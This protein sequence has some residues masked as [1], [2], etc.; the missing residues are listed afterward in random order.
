MSEIMIDLETLSTANNASILTI[1]AIRFDRNSFKI[2]K[3]FYKRITQESNEYYNRDFNQDTIDWWTTQSDQAK[4]EIF[5][6]KNRINLN[7]GL[8]ELS[9]FCRGAKKIW[10]NGAAFDIPILES[11]YEACGLEVPWK[12][13]NVRDVRTIYDLGDLNLNNFKRQN[14]LLGQHH[15][16]LADCETQLAAMEQAMENIYD[17]CFVV[18]D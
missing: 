5:E 6:Y 9:I 13:F 10:A 8:Q 1:G 4:S 17:R 15:N 14:N 7:L 12:F 3:K 11:A 18:Q 16:A 2:T